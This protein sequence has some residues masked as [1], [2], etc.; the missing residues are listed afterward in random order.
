MQSPPNPVLQVWHPLPPSHLG[1]ERNDLTNI[2]FSFSVLYATCLIW[3]SYLTRRSPLLT[4]SVACIPLSCLPNPTMWTSA[5]LVISY[6]PLFIFQLPIS[7]RADSPHGPQPISSP[8]QGLGGAKGWGMSFG[9]PCERRDTCGYY[10]YGSFYSL[11]LTFEPYCVAVVL[12]NTEDPVG[13]R[14]APSYG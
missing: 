5:C 2:F 10:I 1:M 3:N 7:V 9:R 13:L 6:W 4:P 12:H 8:L 11:W 14:I